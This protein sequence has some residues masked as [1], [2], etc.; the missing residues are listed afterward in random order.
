MIELF[1]ELAFRGDG[2]FVVK[3]IEERSSFDN[4]IQCGVCVCVK[5]VRSGSLDI[6]AL[7]LSCGANFAV[8]SHTGITAAT[9]AHRA[10]RSDIFIVINSHIRR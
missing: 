10:Q 1:S 2:E 6:V 4:C 8:T 5:A 3:I 7:L 9:L